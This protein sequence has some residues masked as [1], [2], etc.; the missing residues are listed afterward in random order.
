MNGLDF[1]F[2]TSDLTAQISSCFYPT[3]HISSIF[4][5]ASNDFFF[6]IQLLILNLKLDLMVHID[7]QWIYDDS[8]VRF[9]PK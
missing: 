1:D 5:K 8:M 3:I 2:L 9:Q 4:F 6:F 7:F